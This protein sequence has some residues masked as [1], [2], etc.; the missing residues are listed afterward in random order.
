MGNK[1]LAIGLTVLFT[2]IVLT[3]GHYYGQMG[4]LI[5]L[6]ALLLFAFIYS[7]VLFFIED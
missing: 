2:I 7:T 6:L 3:V 4:I 1:L 5:S